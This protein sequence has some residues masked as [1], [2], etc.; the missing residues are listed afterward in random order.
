[1]DFVGIN[2]LY[3]YFF[4]SIL[5]LKKKQSSIVYDILKLFYIFYILCYCSEK[6]FKLFA[7]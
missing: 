1:M 6:Y 4:R 5:N 3:F 2:E 7:Q